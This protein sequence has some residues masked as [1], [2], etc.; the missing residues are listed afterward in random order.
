VIGGLELQPPTARIHRGGIVLFQR[1]S[2]GAQL[3]GVMV[4]RR[5]GARGR[6][7]PA[8]LSVTIECVVVNGIRLHT[9]PLR[10]LVSERDLGYPLVGVARVDAL[11]SVY[12]RNDG[13]AAELRAVLLVHGQGEDARPMLR[14][15]RD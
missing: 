6:W 3:A 15:L 1:R 7:E 8:R 4:G 2:P 14:A 5:D 13:P 11:V 9:G 12:V 10:N